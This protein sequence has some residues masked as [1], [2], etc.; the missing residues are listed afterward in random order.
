MKYNEMIDIMNV[1][2][3]QL[4]ALKLKHNNVLSCYVFAFE[5]DDAGAMLYSITTTD[6]VIIFQDE[7]GH[8]D[9]YSLFND[10]D[11]Y[12]SYYKHGGAGISYCNKNIIEYISKNISKREINALNSIANKVL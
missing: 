7:Y 3:N 10:A 8:S 5:Q 12:E 1:E 2:P 11:S 6:N 9:L 4:V